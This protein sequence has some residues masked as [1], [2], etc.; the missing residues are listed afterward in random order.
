MTM[1]P[2]ENNINRNNSLHNGKFF[3]NLDKLG[4]QALAGSAICGNDSVRFCGC[5]LTWA[6]C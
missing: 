5:P 3:K 4:N 2:H 1:R 6:S